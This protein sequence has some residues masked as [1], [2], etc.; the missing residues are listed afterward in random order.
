M[1]AISF[2]WMSSTEWVKS[3]STSGRSEKVTMKNSSCGFAV[4]KNSTTA[5]LD[6]SSLFPMLPLMSKIT[7]REMGASSLEKCRISCSRLSSNTAKLCRSR[8]VTR[9][10]RGSVMVTGT[11]SVS[12]RNG[13]VCVLSEGSSGAA[14]G[15]SGCTRGWMCTSP[16]LEPASCAH[17]D[18]GQKLEAK[19]NKTR[20]S[21]D[22]RTGRRLDAGRNTFFDPWHSPQADPQ[23]M[24]RRVRST[25]VERILP[26]FTV[27]PGA[28]NC[29]ALDKM[30]LLRLQVAF[31][32]LATMQDPTHGHGSSLS[33]FAL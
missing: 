12:T 5:S 14:L 24:R 7:P 27:L 32:R 6:R 28:A 3:A 13:L 33:R 30:K 2:P 10:F 23:R 25:F 1:V 26:H 18:E 31:F 15:A 22:T 8:P 20:K 29:T 17:A 16:V 11:R 9:R 21:H 4:V 19:T